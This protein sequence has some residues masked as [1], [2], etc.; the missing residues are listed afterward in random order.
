MYNL[1]KKM[2]NKNMN[3]VIKEDT[4]TKIIKQALYLFK[5]H[6]FNN[7]SIN[8]VCKACGITKGTF[9]YHFNSKEDLLDGFYSLL[10]EQ[11]STEALELLKS[12]SVIEQLWRTFENLIKAI[13]DL[14]P[15]LLK[16]FL[17]IELERRNAFFNPEPNSSI[18]DNSMRQIQLFLIEKGQKSGEIRS[19]LTAEQ[20]YGYFFAVLL[21]TAFDW[22]AKDGSFNKINDLR[23]IF[24]YMF[25][26]DA[27]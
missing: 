5:E 11:S 20:L 17:K 19:K 27:D 26:A 16:Q 9:Y 6:G 10:T 18:K 15:N 3:E 4:K 22:S 2:Y 25:A 12:S 7:V 1:L 24:N 14:G 8:A 13:V 21:G 23:V